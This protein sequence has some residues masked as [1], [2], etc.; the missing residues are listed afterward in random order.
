[1]R[2]NPDGTLDEIWREPDPWW[3]TTS[4][5]EYDELL[6]RI[7]RNNP[8]LTRAKAKEMLDTS[9]KRSRLLR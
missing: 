4:E 3:R 8:T 1:M 5:Q 9:M 2:L 7:L 6:E